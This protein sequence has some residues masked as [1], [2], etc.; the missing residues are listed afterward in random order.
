MEENYFYIRNHKNILEIIKMQIIEFL[1][2]FT[3]Q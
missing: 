2:I 3:N 1:S